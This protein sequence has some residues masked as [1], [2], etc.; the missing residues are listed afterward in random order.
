MCIASIDVISAEHDGVCH[1]VSVLVV[2]MHMRFAAETLVRFG[3]YGYES[4]SA[5]C[6]SYVTRLFLTTPR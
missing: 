2:G 6:I 1:E 3:S 5:H 4:Q